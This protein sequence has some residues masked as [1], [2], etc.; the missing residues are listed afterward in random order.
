ME[1][2][3]VVIRICVTSYILSKRFWNENT[4]R[5]VRDAAVKHGYVEKIYFI[6]VI[7]SGTLSID[8]MRS[9]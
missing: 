7:S 3:I 9:V 5:A 2:W 4:A 6:F 1:K 8:E